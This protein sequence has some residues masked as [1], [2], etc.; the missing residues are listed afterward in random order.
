MLTK[1]KRNGSFFEWK[2]FCMKSVGTVVVAIMVCGFPASLGGRC[3]AAEPPSR[4]ADKADGDAVQWRFHSVL[5]D[6]RRFVSDGS[7]LLE[8][9]YLPDVTV[10]EKSVAPQGVQRLLQSATDQEFGLS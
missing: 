6:G 3:T 5:D 1:V 2:E 8:S 9:R 7:F 10:P 4:P